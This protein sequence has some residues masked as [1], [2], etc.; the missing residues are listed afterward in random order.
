MSRRIFLSGVHGVGKGYFVK[1]RLTH[2][3]NFT[4]ITASEIIAQYHDPEDAGN[5]RVYNVG[6]NQRLLFET[7]K[8]F[9]EKH[10]ETV[11]LDGHLVILD[12]NDKCERIPISFFD[13][14]FDAIIL[15]QDDV[16]AIYDRMYERDGVHKLEK[17]LIEQ[18]Q[19][20][21]REYAKELEKKGIEVCYIT[22]SSKEETYSYL[23]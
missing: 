20:K 10:K 12:E 11:L 17:N 5:K 13:G 1:N 19:E 15:L 23:F 3:G 8:E 14:M 18:I 21:E 2:V 7:L 22:V 16:C 6:E 9:F 4:V